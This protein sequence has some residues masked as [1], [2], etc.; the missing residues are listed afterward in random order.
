MKYIEFQLNLFEA[1]HFNN[2][3]TEN[4]VL[5]SK[6]DVSEHDKNNSIGQSFRKLNFMKIQS[7]CFYQSLYQD[8]VMNTYWRSG[9][10]VKQFE[11]NQSITT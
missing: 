11:L 4:M 10:F 3:I 9:M 5:Y 2:L 8:I 1:E 6:H 7:R